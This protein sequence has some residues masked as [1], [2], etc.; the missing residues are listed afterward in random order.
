MYQNYWKTV[1]TNNHIDI[2]KKKK[3]NFKYIYN[4]K[5]LAFKYLQKVEIIRTKVMERHNK[6]S[7][8]F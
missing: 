6:D 4:K 8:A 1:Q 5:I 2:F 7:T 3:Q